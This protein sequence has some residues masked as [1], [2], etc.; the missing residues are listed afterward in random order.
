MPSASSAL[1]AEHAFGQE[2]GTA[3]R[4]GDASCFVVFDEVDRT[5]TGEERANSFDA[6]AW[7]LGE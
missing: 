5:A 4:N 1:W 7:D 3:E 2:T 6:Q